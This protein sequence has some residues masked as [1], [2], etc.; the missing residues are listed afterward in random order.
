MAGY[1][2]SYGMFADDTPT[3]TG[4]ALPFAAR[5]SLSTQGLV[6]AHSYVSLA[7]STYFFTEF[8]SMALNLAED[9][10]ALASQYQ[11]N[12]DETHVHFVNPLTGAKIL[13]SVK[14][15]F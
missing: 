2:N 8:T 5:Y 15:K 6:W 12:D 11:P 14:F 7:G 9:V 4:R 10:L 13:K 1:S 3:D